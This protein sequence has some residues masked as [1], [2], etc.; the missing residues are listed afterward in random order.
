MNWV[1]VITSFQWV[2]EHKSFTAAAK[3]HYASSSALTKHIQTLEHKIGSP[4]LYRN[5]RH[6]ELTEAGEIFSEKSKRLLHD[7]QSLFDEIDQQHHEISGQLRITI[8]LT[9]T[10]GF[11]SPHLVQFTKRYPDIQLN[12]ICEN[13]YIDLIQHQIDV[14][15]QAG[16]DTDK[17]LQSE[18]LGKKSIGVFASPS[19]LSQ[20]DSIQTPSDIRHHRCLVHSDFITPTIWR[21]QSEQV[22]VRPSLIAN[23]ADTLISAAIEGQG[24]LY[25]SE[26]AVQSPLAS[27]QLKRVLP[28][29]WREGITYQV[30]F[31][32]NKRLPKKIQCFIDFIRQLDW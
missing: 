10:D 5:T 27:G 3:H 20:S 12:I 32:R 26:Y 6:V 7:F 14:A 23:H 1:K 22:A 8:P 9:L 30:V 13:Q 16:E 21:F 19:Y 17:T 29:D 24:L 28:N 2:V 25:L 18:V 4:L 15:I 31:S 11:L